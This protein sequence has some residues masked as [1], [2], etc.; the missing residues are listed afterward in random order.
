M[1]LTVRT[2]LFALGL[3]L[4]ATSR[5]GIA[6]GTRAGTDITNTAQVSYT[7]GAT[8][9]VATS[10]TTS[11]TVL[12]VL[13]VVATVQTPSV[14]VVPGDTRRT[15]TFRITNTGNGSDVFTLTP[16]STVPGGNFNPV[17]ST[18]S[19]IYFDTDGNGFLSAG[20]VAYV[21]GADVT[22][23]PDAAVTIFVLNNIPTGLN[24]G[25]TGLSQVTAVHKGGAGTPGQL[26]PGAGV[27]GIDALFGTTGDQAVQSG[28]YV[29]AN[30]ATLSAVKSEAVVDP[31][32][33]ARPVTGATVTY[34]IVIT[35]GGAGAATAAT[36]SDPIP[37]NTTYKPGSMKLNSI[38]LT[39][40]AG[41]DAG[42]YDAT[43]TPQ[44]RVALG[45]LTAASGAQTVQFAVT[46][47]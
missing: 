11:T 45:D 14:S 32:G 23:A 41:D 21:P 3:A 15:L 28:K 7:V 47:N 37:A 36:F 33:G 12:Q 13:N 46:I 39:D 31:Q 17:L 29:V 19:S 22:L 26:L 1:S 20:D 16:L 27:G 10:N 25:D 44:V 4:L 30:N 8:T 5:P 18:P 6:A 35:P 34:S 38:A 40:A 43:P 24:T 2:W 42:E 9:G